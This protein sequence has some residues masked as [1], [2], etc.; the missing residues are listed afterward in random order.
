MQFFVLAVTLVVL[1]GIGFFFGRSRAL[2]SVS[3]RAKDLHSLPDYYGWY[4][5]LWCGLPAFGLFGL[6][7]LAEP[8]LIDVLVIDR[9]PAALLHEAAG[10]PDLTLNLVHILAAGHA[11]PGKITLGLQEAAEHYNSL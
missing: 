5:A 4:L 11:V 10:S 9:M 2:A 3:G 7:V 8:Y 1:T 6:W